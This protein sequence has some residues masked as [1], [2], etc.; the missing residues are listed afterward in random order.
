MARPRPCGAPPGPV[1]GRRGGPGRRGSRG[2]HPARSGGPAHRTRDRCR[3]AAGCPQPARCAR[4]RLR[5]PG[6]PAAGSRRGARRSLVRRPLPARRRGRR[7]LR[8]GARTQPGGRRARCHVAP[9][10][11]G[12]VAAVAAPRAAAA[13]PGRRPEVVAGIADRRRDR[14]TPAG[15]RL[16]VRRRRRGVRRTGPGSQRRPAAGAVHRP[17]PGGRV[18]TER[19]VPRRGAA[20]LGRPRTAPAAAG[21]GRRVAGADR[22]AGRAVRHV[23]LGAARGALRRPP[24]RARDLGADVRRVRPQRLRAARRGHPADA[25][26]RRRDRAVGAAGDEAAA[27]RPAGPARSALRPVPGDRRVGAVPAAPLRGGVRLHPAAP[28]HERVR[29]LARRPGGA[30]PGGGRAAARGLA[31]AGRGRDRGDRPADPRRPRPRRLRGRAQRRAV[32]EHRQD[33]RGLPPAAVGGRRAGRGHAARAVAVLRA[34]RHAG[35]GRDRAAT[36]AAGTSAGPGPPT[37]W[38]RTRWSSRSAVRLDNRRSRYIVF[39]TDAIHRERRDHHAAVADREPPVP[40]PRGRPAPGGADGGGQ[41]RRGRAHRG[42]RVRAPHRS[43][44]A[45][46]RGR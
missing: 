38:P 9:A 44:S 46:S 18:R 31:G 27:H 11:R 35:C 45:S 3:R 42:R 10:G 12:A 34:G 25:V 21:A 19:R 16:V 22:G 5:H 33:R 43:R 6:F 28:V 29:D 2:R 39:S 1:A 26:R 37:C 23:R 13:D 40:R 20:A 15:V 36:S 7:L 41:R 8:P 17:R 30:G 14:R 32:P 24:A 4:D